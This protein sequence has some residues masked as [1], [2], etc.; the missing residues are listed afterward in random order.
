M[1]EI[2]NIA[3]I[4]GELFEFFSNP[5]H[6]DPSKTLAP[7]SN[8]IFLDRTDRNIDTSIC[9][10]GIISIP[11]IKDLA[12][13]GRGAVMLQLCAMDD[14]VNMVKANQSLIEME[15]NLNAILE[16]SNYLDKNFV[17]SASVA[18][19]DYDD[20]RGVNV[21]IRMLNILIK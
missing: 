9:N 10:W 13:I 5:Q 17:L 2:I 4:K 8:T 3:K 11:S 15:D 16:N 1:K 20:E 6:N 12:V 18:Y 19:S 7:L 21:S 14:V